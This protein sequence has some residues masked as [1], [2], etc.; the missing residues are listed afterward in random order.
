MIIHF[1][2]N[3]NVFASVAHFVGDT[4]NAI[5]NV[6]IM[7]Q[8]N[9]SFIEA[10][11]GHAFCQ[12][13]L[14]KVQSED[15]AHYLITPTRDLIKACKAK[16]ADML[17]VLED[18]SMRVVDTRGNTT[19]IHPAKATTCEAGHYPDTS[20]FIAK[21]DNPHPD[22]VGVTQIS[23][24]CSTFDLFKDAFGKGRIYK[25]TFTGE[26]EPLKVT[27]QDTEFMVIV[28]PMSNR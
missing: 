17:E 10:V 18:M 26:T 6:H 2:I 9:N 11:N 19:Y 8:D 24:P 1:T 15:D 25:F 21:V 22:F 5:D 3:A 12:H 13:A 14:D 20:V 16:N 28:M 27:V 7:I 4:G 23:L